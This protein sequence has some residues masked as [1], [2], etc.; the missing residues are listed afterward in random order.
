MMEREI[1]GKPDNKYYPLPK[2]DPYQ[3][4]S[5]LEMP[6]DVRKSQDTKNPYTFSF[7]MT[8]KVDV[9]NSRGDPDSPRILS[10]HSMADSEKDNTNHE[11]VK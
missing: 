9:T 1:Q 6:T 8:S 2:S 4:H 7:K 3:K 10:M 11:I 5:L